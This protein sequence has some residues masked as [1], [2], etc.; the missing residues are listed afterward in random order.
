MKIE[1]AKEYFTPICLTLETLTEVNI[2][3]ES[4]EQAVKYYNRPNNSIAQGMMN[5]INY[6]LTSPRS[7]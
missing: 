3:K 5:Q 7:L 6:Y 2:I 4:L 1:I